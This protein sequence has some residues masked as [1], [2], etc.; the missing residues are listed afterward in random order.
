[1]ILAHR[2][3]WSAP[4]AIILILIAGKA[5]DAWEALRRPTLLAALFASG[6]AIAINWAIYIWAVTEGR[7]LEG[8][9]GYF[10]NPLFSF[11]IAAVVFREKFNRLQVAAIVLAALGVVNQAVAVGS[12]PWIALS[13]GSTFAIY[14]AIRKQAPVDSRV[15]FGLEAMW[16]APMAIVG[17]FFLRP[18]SA[19][20]F[21][22]Q[23]PAKIALVLAAG[24]VTAIPLM[25]FANGARRL[26]LSTTA[27]LQYIAP[28]LQ[29]IIGLAMGEEFT[30]GHAVTFGLTWAGVSLF[31]LSSWLS[32]RRGSRS[33]EN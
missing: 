3:L 20:I 4:T 18:E 33:G 19:G 9:L 30:P 14:G 16:L 23:D 27:M 22:S 6:M 2:I 8:S 29:F 15:G 12:F 17:L 1:M 7:I 10:I 24:P 28:T 13:L 25:L 32:D 26:K 11:A 21:G 31:T 5:N